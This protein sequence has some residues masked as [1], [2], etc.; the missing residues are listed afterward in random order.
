MDHL[1]TILGERT[2]Y[3]SPSP[4]RPQ[5]P[6][7]RLRRHPGNKVSISEEALPFH[8][9]SRS[10]SRARPGKKFSQDEVSHDSRAN[11]SASRRARFAPEKDVSLYPGDEKAKAK[12]QETKEVP[13]TGEEFGENARIWQVYSEEAAKADTAMTD[14]WNRSMDVLLVFTGLFSAV[15][16][17]FIIQS[18]QNMAPD[19]VDTTNA[20]LSQLI[21]LQFNDSRQHLTL[22]RY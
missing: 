1:S 14:G 5:T 4:S 12:D 17:T 18:Y 20:L 2:P 7:G 10:H 16:T 22:W 9:Q 13:L 21:L 15:L 8:A 6:L 3:A 11:R 19:P